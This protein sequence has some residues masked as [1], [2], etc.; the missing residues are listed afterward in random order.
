MHCVSLVQTN[1]T[2]WQGKNLADPYIFRFQLLLLI[3]V[4]FLSIK[5]HLANKRANGGGKLI[6]GLEG[7]R[8]TL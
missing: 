8:Y 1:V 2:P 6:D 4:A 7:F 3:T 5:F